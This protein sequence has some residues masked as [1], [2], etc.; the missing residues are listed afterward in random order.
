MIV[1]RLIVQPYWKYDSSHI[2][3]EGCNFETFETNPACSQSVLN[4]VLPLTDF[5]NCLKGPI[6]WD[7]GCPSTCVCTCCRAG[8][9]WTPWCGQRCLW[10][11]GWGSG[12]SWSPP[13]GGYGPTASRLTCRIV[14]VTTGTADC[15]VKRGRSLSWLRCGTWPLLL[16]LQRWN[17]HCHWSGL[18]CGQRE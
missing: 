8:P 5:S 2:L 18:L 6:H 9:G 14:A 13:A 11:A 10:A 4:I 3:S 15:W 16:E 17:V 1:I 7:I 12:C